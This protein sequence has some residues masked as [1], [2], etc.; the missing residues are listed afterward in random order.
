MQSDTS[1][2]SKL[3]IVDESPILFAAAS[4][5]HG[6][7]D[8]SKD[9]VSTMPKG[10]VEE[11]PILFSPANRQQPQHPPQQQ[12]QLV[13]ETGSEGGDTGP[14][15][16]PIFFASARRLQQGLDSPI[17]FSAAGRTNTAQTTHT[18]TTFPLSGAAADLA[19]AKHNSSQPPMLGQL[20]PKPWGSPIQFYGG[21]GLNMVPTPHG[22]IGR[23]DM[24]LAF[25]IIDRCTVD[26]QQLQQ[27]F[28]TLSTTLNEATTKALESD[29][30]LAQLGA[31]IELELELS[32]IHHQL[33][34]GIEEQQLPEVQKMMRATQEMISRLNLLSTTA[35]AG[36]ATAVVMPYSAATGMRIEPS[37][38]TM[39]SNGSAGA[40]AGTGTGTGAGGLQLQG[41]GSTGG[42][43]GPMGST[44]IASAAAL[45]LAKLAESGHSS[46][47]PSSS[48]IKP[49][50][51]RD[52]G[53]GNDSTSG[54]GTAMD[55]DSQGGH[56]GNN[57]SGTISM[58][59]PTLLEKMSLGGQGAGQGPGQ[60]QGAVLHRPCLSFNIAPKGCRFLANQTPCPYRHVCLYCGS[61][62]HVV[63]EC[64]YTSSEPSH[65]FE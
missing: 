53:Y 3:L 63:M 10:P 9:G 7:P 33:K 35:A 48:A 1:A 50:T 2:Q 22:E 39:S 4:R 16:S 62:D 14:K 42:Y 31:Q 17:L 37:S 29:A 59:R 30:R 21:S 43:K 13:M 64:D 5:M 58:R 25:E 47:S 57:N 55:V 28:V 52:L 40:E 56:G 20:G 6:K 23:S 15:D 8:A 45:A 60:G 19:M 27:R 61:A 54:N 32:Q 34:N 11:A 65:D 26:L 24:S 36:S 18:S 41:Q 44:P 12:Q 51:E 46:A 38:T 49:E